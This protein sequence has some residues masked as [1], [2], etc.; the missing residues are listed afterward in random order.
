M[1]SMAHN[2]SGSTTSSFQWR[3]VRSAPQAPT[4]Q[5][6]KASSQHRLTRWDAREPLTLQVTYRGGSEA[7]YEVRARGRTYRVP[8]HRALVDV[9]EQVYD[10]RGHSRY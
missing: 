8:G 5:P 10:D 4:G 6:P 2:R 1:R 3:R 9:M 7:W